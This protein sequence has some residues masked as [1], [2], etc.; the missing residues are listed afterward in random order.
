[1]QTFTEGEVVQKTPATR[2]VQFP[3]FS[4]EKIEYTRIF[5][6]DGK[7]SGEVREY[8]KAR[9]GIFQPGNED[10]QGKGYW[11]VPTLNLVNTPFVS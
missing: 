6:A 1:M 7:P 2:E 5:F 8:L 9:K 3:K 11:Q 10:T 4:T